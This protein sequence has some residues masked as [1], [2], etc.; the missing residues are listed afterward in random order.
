MNEPVC[1]PV[2][3]STAIEERETPLDLLPPPPSAV[4]PA[5][6]GISSHHALPSLPGYVILCELGR[7]GM[8]RVFKARHLRLNRIVAL[9]MLHVAEFA[10]AEE[11]ERFLKEAQA[12]ATLQHPHVVQIFEAGE[13]R[14]RL[15]LV[16]ECL[17]GGSLDKR[18]RGQPLEP[19]AA[20][21]LVETLA[22]AVQHVHNRG[23]LHRDLKLANVLVD[24]EPEAPLQPD[25]IK[26]TDFG[27][28][29]P[30]DRG[31]GSSS[32]AI[33]G[34]PNYMAPE[35]AQGQ[36]ASPVSDVYSLGAILYELMCGRPPFVGPTWME[37]LTQVIGLEPAP[38]RRLVPSLPRDLETIC[39][40]CLQKA[41]G[42]R[43]S[44]AAHLADELRRFLDGKPIR[45]RPVSRL[46]RGLKWV[47][48]NPV[49][50]ALL[51]AVIVASTIGAVGIF[52]NYRDAR[53]QEAAARK[54][55]QDAVARGNEAIKQTGIA[56]DNEGK[57]LL[58]LGQRDDALKER[59][60]NSAL[61]KILLAQAAFDNSDPALAL[62]R[63]NLVPADWRR[64]EWHYL[65]RQFAGGIYTLQGH[66]GEVQCASFSRD[67]KYIVTGGRDGAK[68][69]DARTGAHLFDLKGHEV[70]VAAASFSRD[71]SRIV[72]GSWDNTAM[73]WDARTGK[74]L[75][76]LAGH[77]DMVRSVAFSPDGSR[78]VTGSADKT[79][80]VWDANA[81]GKP[82]LDIKC[83]TQGVT[84]GVE[85]VTFSP[86]GTLIVAG[87]WDK[88]ARILD[89][90]TGM[91]LRELSGHTAVVLSV[92]FSPDGTRVVTGSF[93]GTAKVFD[94]GNATLLHELRGHLLGVTG[95]AFSPDGTRI[96]TSSD[97]RTAR[98]WDARTGV[99]LVTL[100]GH[101]SAVNSVAFGPDSTRVVSSSKD[102]TAKVWDVRRGTP[103]LELNVRLISPTGSAF[104]PDCTRIVTGTYGNVAKVWDARSGELVHELKGHR[105]RVSSAAYSSDGTRIVTASED[106]TAIVWDARSGTQLFD[107]KDHS[108][109]VVS[110]AFSTDGSRI[111]T[112]SWDKTAKIW[113]ATSGKLLLTLDKH[114][115]R[116][117]AASFSADGTR[118]VTASKDKT[119][120]V[121]EAT[122]GSMLFSLPADP[123]IVHS[124]AYS[125]DGTRI[126]TAGG[127]KSAKV[128]DA[129]N[130]KHL[131]DL[132]GHT[133]A[134][135][136]VSYSHDGSRIVTASHDKTAKVWDAKTGT[137]L[138]SIEGHANAVQTATFSRDG[139]RI[140][141]GGILDPATIWDARSYP[142][143]SNEDL[144]Y[145]QFW[146]RP[147]RE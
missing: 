114:I 121:W 47:R 24:A 26:L 88:S 22:N 11:R 124:A 14:D 99:S 131:L 13:D 67:G 16:M 89:A 69:W 61:D 82:L 65:V 113:D 93:D 18:L 142:A 44:S 76:T 77:T 46:E 137:P 81:G 94:A 138:Y 51:A 3:R 12:L 85:C 90:K 32:R 30:I 97:D 39:L 9:K 43:Y 78:I 132:K 108:Q 87:S 92:C 74:R 83:R 126:I 15:Y 52:L 111:V 53:N 17:E 73:V 109:N 71:G 91:S 5:Q 98:I 66:T 147:R 135:L 146:M 127:D 55:E 42:K 80:K 139:T 130:G 122:T 107:L 129:T 34:T 140:I 25:K 28:A 144:A 37:T 40:T 141:T 21:Q 60:Y 143:G 118:V 4:S 119:V 115:D 84:G 8:G 102:K 31:G 6:P 64:W 36:P 134:V 86:D 70:L 35:Q 68:V 57:A 48:R 63:I 125:P 45:A 133:E 96:A 38:P 72:T 19:K 117:T 2:E 105:F 103:Q 95:V 33:V 75:L 101:R 100:K 104:S 10:V 62:E 116:L 50:S 58:A 110:A 7:G 27:L 41:P 112:A 20:A 49:V 56:K 106:R 145:R 59:D 23:L 136:G 128:W 54:N 79:V 1:E 123:F 120:K 29:K